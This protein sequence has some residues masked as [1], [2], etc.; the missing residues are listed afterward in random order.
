MDC[1]GDLKITR[2]K[3]PIGVEKNMRNRLRTSPVEQVEMTSY[4]VI[5]LEDEPTLMNRFVLSDIRFGEFV[6][7]SSTLSD[8]SY[9][10]LAHDSVE[11]S[12]PNRLLI[13]AYMQTQLPDSQGQ[14]E[15]YVEALRVNHKSSKIT[16]L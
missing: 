5:S 15:R 2:L 16:Y 11:T 12:K 6:I 14:F 7:C 10:Q 4:P 8:S 3:R 1:C 13:R 9:E